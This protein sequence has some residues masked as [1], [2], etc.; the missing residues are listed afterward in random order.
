MYIRSQNKMKMDIFRDTYEQVND[1]E[2]ALGL[3]CIGSERD[4]KII[5]DINWD[6]IQIIR[7]NGNV[8][9]HKTA[10]ELRPNDEFQVDCEINGKYG[11]YIFEINDI[12]VDDG[13]MSFVTNDSVYSTIDFYE[14]YLDLCE[15]Y[16]EIKEGKHNIREEDLVEIKKIGA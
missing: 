13:E 9:R 7:D 8:M 2:I 10:E 14:Q 1:V 6:S 15:K 11:T 16:Q 12:V 3:E 5:T 4:P